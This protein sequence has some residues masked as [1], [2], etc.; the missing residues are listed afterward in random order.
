MRPIALLALSSSVALIGFALAPASALAQE[1][2]G[3]FE[4]S[5]RNINVDGGMLTAE[6]R[7]MRGGYHASTIPYRR[8]RGD[9]GNNDGILSCDGA[10]GQPVGGPG[11][12]Y[13]DE[14][15]APP[16]YPDFSRIEDHIRDHIRGGVQSGIQPD[17][18]HA[19]FGRLREIREHE[20]HAYDRYGADLPPDVRMRIREDLRDLDHRVDEAL[21]RP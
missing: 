11:P 21:G 13:E 10:V 7:D 6:C 18:A 3:S 9:I 5:C 12:G 19:L 15:A 4:A 16:I 17:D 1:P 20:Q 8:C 14:G 2:R